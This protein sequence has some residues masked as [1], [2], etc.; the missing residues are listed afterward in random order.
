MAHTDQDME[1]PGWRLSI[2]AAISCV[3]IVGMA[4]GLGLPLLAMNLERMTGSG[5]VIG[6]NALSGAVSIVVAAPFAPLIL[7]RYPA[8]P[9]LI[10]SLLLTSFSYIFYRLVD[11]VTLWMVMR[12]ISGFTISIL[13]IASETWINQL[14]PNHLRAR[15]LS[16]YSIALAAGFGLGGLLVAY[17]GISGWAPF[18]AGAIICLLG[19]LP[20]LAPGP[21][22]IA[23]DRDEVSPSILFS[24]FSKAPRIMLAALAFGAIE[25]AATHFSPVWALR[26]G[27]GETEAL[28]LIS[29][30][31]IGVIALQ[32]PIGWLGDK[33]DRY[34]LLVICGVATLIAPILM[35]LTIGLSTTV[36]Y[37][38]FFIYVG[39]GEGLYILALVLVGQKFGKKE[40]TAASAALVLMYGIGS[41]L[42]P[43]VIG[44][45][46]D[47]FNPHGAMFGLA[48]FAVIYLGA[49]FWFR[50]RPTT[51]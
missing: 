19:I 49:A 51:V 26:A 23:P 41:M 35:W 38:I 14:A 48:L 12:F 37:I 4:F 1:A 2:A 46:M 3:S 24:Y 17:L 33:M 25:T 40:L 10:F 31:A 45:L 30:G 42:S 15:L 39:M 43:L 36:L 22:L 11:S 5:L 9:I 13:F 32:F 34:R 27:L 18:V 29:V 28:R 44:P 20:L 47:V 7:S 50:G 21:Q 16:I 6:I 8:R